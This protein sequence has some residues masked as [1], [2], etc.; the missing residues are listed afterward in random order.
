LAHIGV[1]ESLSSQGLR[2]DLVI[3]TSM[4]AIVGGLYA[5]GMSPRELKE[6][7][8]RFSFI[9]YL[10]PPPFSRMKK[11]RPRNILDFM[12]IETYRNRLMKKMGLDQEDRIESTLHNLVGDATIEELP[13]PFA[14]NAVDLLTGEEVVFTKGKLARAIRASISLP[15]LFEPVKWNGRLLADGGVLDNAPVKIARRLGAA[16]TFLVDIHRP[17]QV[18]PP[19]RI[20]NFFQLLQRL[21]ETMSYHLTIAQIKEA[22]FSLRV[23]VDVDAMDFSRTQAIIETGRRAAEANMEK[24]LKFLKSRRS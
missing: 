23:E 4:G 16:K 1:L 22:D 19:E 14:C 8:F 5:Y 17:L 9:E 21:M 6:T 7:A 13:L 10:V 24:T 11:I 20:T 12:L 2:P 3:G 15:F 18:L